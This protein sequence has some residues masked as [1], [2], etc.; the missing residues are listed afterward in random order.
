[1]NGGDTRIGLCFCVP[2]AHSDLLWTQ[3]R[4]AVEEYI[5][6]KIITCT[7]V[8]PVIHISDLDHFHGQWYKILHS[9]ATK[10]WKFIPNTT[11]VIL[12]LNITDVVKWR[13]HH[14]ETLLCII[15][16]IVIHWW[17][18]QLPSIW[19][20]HVFNLTLYSNG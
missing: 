14:I 8:Y 18:C 1:M 3:H 6:G 2:L 4:Q 9:K 11:P 10:S 20:Q 5:N 19:H 12:K 17:I 16:G 13:W 7:K 15:Q